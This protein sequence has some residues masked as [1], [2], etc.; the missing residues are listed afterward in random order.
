MQQHHI[1]MNIHV[2]GSSVFST[3]AGQE[4]F[5]VYLNISQWSEPDFVQMPEEKPEDKQLVSTLVQDVKTRDLLFVLSRMQALVGC[6]VKE[7]S[8]AGYVR[9]HG[10]GLGWGAYIPS[11]FSNSSI[12]YNPTTPHTFSGAPWPLYY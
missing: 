4:I 10:E 11:T 6:L 2:L 5:L 1:G 12:S 7:C 8:W 3:L 9:G